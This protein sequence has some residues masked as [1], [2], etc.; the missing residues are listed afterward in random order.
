[1]QVDRRPE[2]RKD[3]FK[4]GIV[5]R[6]GAADLPC[7]VWDLSS[8][9]AKL[10]FEAPEAAPEAFAL[11]VGAD[12]RSRPCRVIWRSGLR[13]GVAFQLASTAPEA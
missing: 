8:M 11:V 13:L 3:A 10:E 4:F 7:L 12:G 9:G 1:M 2:F 5:K 6:E